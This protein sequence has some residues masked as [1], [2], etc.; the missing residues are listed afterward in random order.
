MQEGLVKT[1]KLSM[2]GGPSQYPAKNISPPLVTRKN[3]VTYKKGYGPAVIGDN[4]DRYVVFFV[5][6][7]FLPVTPSMCSIMFLKRSQS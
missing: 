2:P 6:L 7:I 1:E 5:I 4:P 3:P